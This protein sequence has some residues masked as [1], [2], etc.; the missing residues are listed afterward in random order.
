MTKKK[1]QKISKNMVVQETPDLH[2]E[3]K[4]L[5]AENQLLR[6]EIR[7]K[8]STLAE[9]MVMLVLKKKEGLFSEDETAK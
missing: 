6:Q 2:A 3:V 1:Y 8:D 9:A 5:R 4:S 7:R